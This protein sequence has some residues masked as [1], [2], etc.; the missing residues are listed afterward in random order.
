VIKAFSLQEM[1]VTST[2]MEASL[3]DLTCVYEL[4]SLMAEDPVSSSS[5][6]ESW[7]VT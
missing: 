4:P 2:V 6:S 5:L 7:E 3:A 1:S